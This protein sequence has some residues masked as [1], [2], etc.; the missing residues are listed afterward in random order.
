M[1]IEATGSLIT[2]NIDGK[3]LEK[4]IEVVSDGIRALY[5]ENLIK[6]DNTMKVT[7]APILKLEDNDVELDEEK[8]F[9][10]IEGK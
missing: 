1:S 3:P 9:F 10:R 6:G 4:L 5:A 2:I 7:C 8:T